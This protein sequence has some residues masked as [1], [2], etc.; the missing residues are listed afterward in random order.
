MARLSCHAT[1]L[2]GHAGNNICGF[3]GCLYGRYWARTSDPQLVDTEQTFARVRSTFDYPCKSALSASSVFAGVRF[4][5]TL[6]VHTVH[7]DFASFTL[8]PGCQRVTS[9]AHTPSAPGVGCAPPGGATFET[10]YR[11]DPRR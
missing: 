9:A 2:V 10:W 5:R 11:R 3:T 1:P 7:T 6:G 8:A 4:D